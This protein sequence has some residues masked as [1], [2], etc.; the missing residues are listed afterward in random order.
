MPSTNSNRSHPHQSSSRIPSNLNTPNVSNNS[1]QPP[2]VQTRLRARLGSLPTSLPQPSSSLP[3]RRRL[4]ASSLMPPG[5]PLFEQAGS[6]TLAMSPRQSPVATRPSTRAAQLQAQQSFSSH[7]L[8][9]LLN[10]CFS[11]SGSPQVPNLTSKLSQHDSSLQDPQISCSFDQ[12]GQ[13]EKMNIQSTDPISFYDSGVPDHLEEASMEQAPDQTSLDWTMTDRLRLWRDDARAQHLYETAAFWGAKVYG[14]TSNP[15]DAFWLAQVYFLTGQFVRAEKILTGV[16]RIA[17]RPLDLE[18]INPD[19]THD[20]LIVENLT[21]AHPDREKNEAGREETN[22][23][24]PVRM[25]DYSTACRYLAA[26][27]MIRQGKWEAAMEMVGDENPFRLESQ[28]Q[29]DLDQPS[30]LAS[31]QRGPKLKG[32][33]SEHVDHQQGSSK[34]GSMGKKYADSKATM[35][36]GIKFE[37]SMCYLRG[38]VHLQNKSLDRAKE[39]FLESLALDVKC[40]ESFE[41]LVGGNM[42]EPEEEW[43]FIQS[44]GYHH[45]TPDDALFI[46]SLY[47]VRLKKFNHK[48]EVFEAFRLLKEKYNLSDDPDAAFGLADWLFTNYRF[49][50]CHRIT[51]RILTLHDHHPPTLPLHLTCMAMMPHLRPSLFL[52]AHDLVERDPNSAIS[53]YAAGL[54]YFSQRRWEESRRFFSKSA[55][56]D[57]RFAPAW[58]GFGHAL[59]YEGEHDQAITAYST[60][61]HNFQ[62]SH[63]PLLFIGMQHIQ[64]ANPTLA[65]DYLLAASEICPFDP[66]VLHERGVVCY[67]Q[68]QWQEGAELFESTIKASQ[69][70][71]TDP[72]IWA[73]TYLN[74]SHCYRRL[75]RYPEALEAAK[76][77]KYLQP[78]SAAA[79]TATG[80]AFHALGNNS[81]AIRMYHESLAVLP[82]DPMTTSLLKFS[83]DMEC[84]YP[85][86]QTNRP[87]TSPPVS[88]PFMFKGL[89]REGYEQFK[90]DLEGYEE[91]L[92]TQY[93][94]ECTSSTLFGYAPEK[95]AGTS[96]VG[97][98]VGGSEEDG[99]RMEE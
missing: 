32:Q 17:R 43:E 96:G 3:L 48:E 77:A 70:S 93:G 79:L 92:K 47:T 81:D 90:E 83:L 67:Y 55:L 52:L 54:W 57:S 68:E 72:K 89:S 7:S 27:C 76:Q 8:T 53:W 31:S 4:P 42:L 11:T 16:R 22:D 40:Y 10:R 28:N 87:S 19:S 12:D 85:I 33:R 21:A 80:M 25:T 78:R 39:C 26:Q 49:Q 56:M 58:F 61:S 86:L 66:L 64:L 38:L 45:Q 34:T 71:Q 74:L 99:D 30:N 97:I 41:A 60:A 91:K 50:D 9:P 59:A 15:N 65:S 23:L 98:G 51:S 73:P 95:E 84:C 5:S 2:T 36:G 94:K 24:A 63:F 44:L 88:P 20:D 82:A 18:E 14:L 62:G 6:S 37:S 46:K 13:D 75:K 35:D 29:H 1:N 69:N